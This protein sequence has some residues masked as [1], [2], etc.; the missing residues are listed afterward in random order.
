MYTLLNR[1]CLNFSDPA[2]K[3][4]N[5]YFGFN[6]KSNLIGI[7]NTSPKSLPVKFM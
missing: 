1:H 5:T 7:K 2:G 3:V 4:Q 6:P